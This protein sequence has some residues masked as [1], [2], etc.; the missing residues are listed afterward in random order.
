MLSL[1]ISLL[2]IFVAFIVLCIALKKNQKNISNYL[3]FLYFLI[4]GLYGIAHDVII[5]ST[6]SYLIY[7]F[8][9]HFTPL[10]ICIGPILYLYTK[11]L[12]ENQNNKVFNG[13][14]L[15]HLI[16]F[17]IILFD[18]L[19][20]YFLSFEEKMSIA[21]SF[22]NNNR[23]FSLLKHSFLTDFQSAFF[24]QWVNMGYISYAVFYKNVKKLHPICQKQS[25]SIK[26]WLRV[27]LFTNLLFS[28]SMIDYYLSINNHYYEFRFGIST[29]TIA[30]IPWVLHG[31][32]IASILLFP[33]VLYGLPQ[34]EKALVAAPDASMET[35]QKTN[36]VIEEKVENQP[37]KKVY[38]A[39]ELDDA[40]LHK[41]H[42]LVENFIVSKPYIEDKF[43]LSVLTAE[44]KIPTHHLQLYF[45]EYLHTHFNHWKNALKIKYAIELIESGILARITIET[46]AIKSGFKS[47][48]NFFIVFKSHTGITPS[49]YIVQ[50]NN[51][52]KKN[53]PEYSS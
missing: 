22:A 30:N 17:L 50:M 31:M 20:H 11:S 53:L 9:N 14:T 33:G 37:I 23:D 19:P 8:L 32:I 26:N 44:T 4:H 16:P 40:Y 45:K 52:M 3:L 1:S 21:K 29:A 25:K 35:H 42:G 27:I 24:R 12:L 43:S 5:Y 34:F 49:E 18:Q 51:S 2:S 10:F 47:Y 38:K 13:W 36:E 46:I 41:I 39:F 6:N 7:F 28:I 15:L 48:S